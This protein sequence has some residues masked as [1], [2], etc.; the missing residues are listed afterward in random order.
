MSWQACRKKGINT[1]LSQVMNPKMKNK[2]P[3]IIIGTR[4]LFCESIFDDI[5]NFDF[6]DEGFM[7]TASVSA[8]TSIFFFDRATIGKLFLI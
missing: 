8:Q 4:K 2:L 7:L 1:L 6:K 5:V 3:I